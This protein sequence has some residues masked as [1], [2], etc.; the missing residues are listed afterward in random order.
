MSAT[1]S[2]KESAYSKTERRV[3]EILRKLAIDFVFEM[4]NEAELLRELMPEPPKDA[5]PKEIRSFRLRNIIYHTA[6]NRLKDNGCMSILVDER[7]RKEYPEFNKEVERQWSRERAL[8]ILEEVNP[9]P[10]RERTPVEEAEE[11]VLSKLEELIPRLIDDYKRSNGY[12]L[13]RYNQKSKQAMRLAVRDLAVQKVKEEVPQEVLNLLEEDCL[14][15][16]SSCLIAR[17]C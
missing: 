11:I 6:E 1:V 7:F 5:T 4:R 17:C 9:L 14:K 13:L 15:R 8:E 16:F 3:I 10:A 12:E 2:L